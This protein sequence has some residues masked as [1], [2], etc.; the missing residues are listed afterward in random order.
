VGLTIA[1]IGLACATA[2]I[3][4][5]SGYADV[6]PLGT[7]IG[8]MAMVISQSRL[9]GLILWLLAAAL[10]LARPI[11]GSRLKC[12]LGCIGISLVA[13]ACI[14]VA[15]VWANSASLFFVM[16]GLA[17]SED[18]APEDRPTRREQMT[19]V[20]GAAIVLATAS[21]MVWA[22]PRVFAWERGL[23]DASESARKT[24][25]L[26]VRLAAINQ[27]A[28]LPGDSLDLWR[29][30]V[31]D[32]T[33][34]VASAL[35]EEL[36]NRS[37]AESALDAS[38]ELL[39]SHGGL[40]GILEWVPGA[41]LPLV[42]GEAKQFSHPNTLIAASE[43]LLSAVDAMEQVRTEKPTWFGKEKLDQAAAS[44]VFP[45]KVAANLQPP[46]SSAHGAL[47]RAHLRVAST[48]G[49]DSPEGRESIVA[50]ISAF[51]RAAALDPHGITY[52]LQLFELARQMG[53][54]EL[55]GKWAEELL[56]R[57]ENMA[58]D[59]VRALTPEQVSRARTAL[60]PS[61]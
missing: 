58:L 54:R 39:E 17:A 36:L 33:N 11:Q 51:E 7:T 56:R 6:L 41:D 47:A 9:P 49:V 40:S 3:I 28:P 1:V 35:N 43:A 27:R 13:S 55:A 5:L 16:L 23:V 29:L 2:F 21:P 50:A 20:V 24:G 30:D 34:P 4:E 10:L 19:S 14:D 53:D 52:P 8:D 12:V 32:H 42:N 60:R 25:M 37:I 48:H 18:V 26:S 46:S 38:D 61:P 22:A 45:A 31:Q 59:P 44:A 57:N 15:P